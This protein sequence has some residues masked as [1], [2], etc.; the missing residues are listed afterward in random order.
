MTLDPLGKGDWEAMMRSNL[1]ALVE[2]FGGA[3]TPA[4]TPP[5]A[6]GT[7]TGDPRP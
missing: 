2:A 1:D 6:E 5:A 3:P 4:P 7:T